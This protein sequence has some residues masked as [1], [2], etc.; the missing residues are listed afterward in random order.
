[1]R[2]TAPVTGSVSGIGLACIKLLLKGRYQAIAF[3]LQENLMR[4]NHPEEKGISY[5]WG[6]SP[7]RKIVLGI[8]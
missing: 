4:Q 8:R 7:N 5:F 3:D 6:M 2:R 1:M